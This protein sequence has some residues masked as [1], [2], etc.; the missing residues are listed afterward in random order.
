MGGRSQLPQPWLG[1]GVLL[2]VALGCR[3]TLR[4]AGPDS[5]ATPSSACT[6]DQD[7]S[8]SSLHC[9]PASGVCFA[10]VS[11]ANCSQAIGHPRCD[12]AEHICVQCG[13]MTDC[14]AGWSCV[15]ATCVQTCTTNASCSAAGTFCDDGLCNACDDD[16]PCPAGDA[17]YCNSETH[18]CAS[19]TSDQHCTAVAPR[20]NP[21]VG[22]CVG[23][24]TSLDCGGNGV[25]DPSD[26]VCKTPGPEG[27]Q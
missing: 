16:H 6:S 22:N 9:D 17:P 12:L 18:Q 8:L 13:L 19:C 5:G 21:S 24:L 20:C 14:P 11:D 27:D 2:M 3:V 4:F 23:C 7:C 25:C 26:W 15:S 1:L 10:C